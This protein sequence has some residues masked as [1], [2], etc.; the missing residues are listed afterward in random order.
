VEIESAWVA[1]LQ[2][3]IGLVR[4]V[5]GVEALLHNPESNWLLVLVGKNLGAH[6]VQLLLRSQCD[7][8]GITFKLLGVKF[9]PGWCPDLAAVVAERRHLSSIE[10]SLQVLLNGTTTLGPRAT[11]RLWDT[12]SAGLV[13][14]FTWFRF[15]TGERP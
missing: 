15:P 13:D 12:S 10:A 11:P 5:M 1:E 3:V 7:L 4:L 9:T 6:Q 8:A 2:L 14:Q